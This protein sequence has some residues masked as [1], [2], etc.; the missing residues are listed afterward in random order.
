V[1]TN[2]STLSPTRPL[3][4]TAAVAGLAVAGLIIFAGNYNVEK[5]QNG[6]LGPAIITAAGCLLVTVVVYGAVLPHMRR[7]NRTAVILG[8][9]AVLSLAAFWSGVTPVLAGAALAANAGKADFNRG[10]RIAQAASGRR[11]S[12]CARRGARVKPLAPSDP[13]P[14]GSPDVAHRDGI[15]TAPRRDGS[16]SITVRTGPCHAT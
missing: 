13:C 5:G 10:A 4:Q 1:T 12:H 7:P 16:R 15:R 2:T 8:V 6:G 9:L 11:H 3:A 14:L